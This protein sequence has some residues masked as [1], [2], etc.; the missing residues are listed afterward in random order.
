MHVQSA[1]ILKSIIWCLIWINEPLL[2]CSSVV[3]AAVATGAFLLCWCLF[4]LFVRLIWSLFRLC[5]DVVV[6]VEE[7]T[8][9]KELMDAWSLGFFFLLKYFLVGLVILRYRLWWCWC[10]RWCW[11][12]TSCSCSSSCSSSSSS[13]SSPSSLWIMEVIK[14][15]CDEWYFLIFDRNLWGWRSTV[16]NE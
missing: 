6:V 15:K 9:E 16:S 13:S 8:E 14:C 12:L 11:I 4:L 3:V 10:G 2:S 5:D 1:G 7:D